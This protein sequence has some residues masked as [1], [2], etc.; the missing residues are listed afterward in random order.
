[1]TIR[2]NFTPYFLAGPVFGKINFR[3]ELERTTE[4]NGSTYTELNNTK[5]TGGISIGLRGGVGVSVILNKKLNL[6]SE[7]TY[8]GMNY[9]P[10]ESEI[11]RYTFNGE[12][13]LST[14]P[15]RIRKTIYVEKIETNSQT[16]SDNVNTPGKSTRFPVTMSSL[17]VNAGVLINLH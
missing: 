14:L 10:K 17:N 16:A 6:F 13:K 12:D 11:T 8:T 7:I 9:Y 4:E 5:F 2:R 1:M 15:Q 3:R